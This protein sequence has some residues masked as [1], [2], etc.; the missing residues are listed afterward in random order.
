MT[1]EPPSQLKSKYNLFPFLNVWSLFAMSCIYS[2][3]T[4]WFELPRVPTIVCIYCRSAEIK[5]WIEVQEFIPY[6][7]QRYIVH[8]I[9][10]LKSSDSAAVSAER[11]SVMYSVT[12]DHVNFAGDQRISV[13]SSHG[14]HSCTVT[15]SYNY[16][17]QRIY[18]Y[19]LLSCH[20][21]IPRVLMFS[22][23]QKNYYEICN[24]FE[25]S[26]VHA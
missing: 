9:L 10:T 14:P 21:I 26:K 7:L 23:E 5:V 16:H 11:S 8:D 24:L 1:D 19:G 18:Q 2:Q 17:L 13:C 25:T 12:K 6:A 4:R 3:C 22:M 15:L 20:N